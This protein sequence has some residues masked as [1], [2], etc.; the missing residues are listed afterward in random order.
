MLEPKTRFALLPICLLTVGCASTGE[1]E[2][3]LHTGTDSPVSFSQAEL[4]IEVPA[5]EMASGPSIQK[6]QISPSSLPV[7]GGEVEVVWTGATDAAYCTLSIE[8]SE[9]V[10]LG[11][12][13][14]FEATI[15]DSSEVYMACSDVNNN[16]GPASGHFVQVQPLPADVIGKETR[17]AVYAGRPLRLL[18]GVHSATACSYSRLPSPSLPQPGTQ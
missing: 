18:N 4:D 2:T 10:K 14:R 1:F 16:E 6:L 3:Y 15:I 9:D 11:P 5:V 8:G 13:G 7:G 12:T 17:V